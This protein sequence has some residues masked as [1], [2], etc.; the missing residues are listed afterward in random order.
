[1]TPIGPRICG[2]ALLIAIVSVPSRAASRHIEKK[3]IVNAVWRPLRTQHGVFQAT[4]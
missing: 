4:S 2:R 1:M 3:R